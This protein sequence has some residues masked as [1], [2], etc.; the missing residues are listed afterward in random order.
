MTDT[1]TLCVEDD[2]ALLDVLL[3]ES[4]EI[5]AEIYDDDIEAKAWVES[6]ITDWPFG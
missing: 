6:A 4:A 2:T 1:E 5:I 3:A